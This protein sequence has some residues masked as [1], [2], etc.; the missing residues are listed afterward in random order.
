LADQTRLG[1][2]PGPRR[3]LV[4]DDEASVRQT[5]ALFLRRAGYEPVLAQDGE[6]AIGLL[7]R[8]TQF[9]LL[10]T[11]QSM[12]GMSG[13]QLIIE[14]ARLRPSLP[15]MLITGYERV[16]GIEFLQGRVTVL[17]KPFER[18]QFLLQVQA[19]LGAVALCGVLGGQGP[20]Q[21]A[22]GTAIQGPARSPANQRFG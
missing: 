17:N 9:D 8:G 21:T 2:L 22:R 12:P 16:A 13:T 10:V 7:Q 19:L 20:S 15:T 11:D 14:V 4:V 1:D 3:V 18:A 6:E 5:L